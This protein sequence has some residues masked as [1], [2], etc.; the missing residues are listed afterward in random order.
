M[1]NIFITAIL[2][3]WFV[4]CST[5]ELD[6]S[7]ISDL[8][9]NGFYSNTE[10]FEIA[11]NG[12]YSTLRFFPDTQFHLQEVR[13]DNMYAITETGV[14]P[15]EPVNNLDN[16]IATNTYLSDVWDTNFEGILRVN[17]I[18]ESLNDNVVSDQATRERMEG[19]AKFLRAFFYFDLVKTFG[20]VPLI[21]QV[22]TPAQTLEIGR[23]D[24]SEIYNLIVSDLNAAISL[25]PPSFS[26]NQL[27]KATSW[28]AKAM[29]G[30]VYLTKSGPTYGI[31]G[32]GLN[33]GEYNLAID[34]FDDV[35]NNGPFDYEDDY[36]TI[37]DYDNENNSEII[38]DIQYNSG[39]EVG[40]DYPSITVPD[41]YLRANGAGFTNGEDNKRVSEDLINSYD[42]LDVRD[43]VTIID[44]YTD[45]NNIFNDVT[46][47]GKY[48]DLNFKG[49]DRFDWGLNYPVI[50]Y[51]DVQLMRAEA[52]LMSNT[53]RQTD[54]DTPVNFIR[55]R[56]GL[57]GNL[58]N[59]DIDGLLAEKRLEF[60]GENTRW[61]DLVRTGKVVQVMNAWITND[62]VSGKIATMKEDFVIYP[63]PSNQITVKEGLYQQNEGYN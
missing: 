38:F 26:G 62:D 31:E 42:L 7:P 11:I 40:A 6:Q 33:S 37:F 21:D 51:T 20:K 57:V 34:L 48:I 32:P 50:R 60:A 23:S 15:F 9:A 58:A 17:T 19:E 55:T 4:S 14:R 10:E 30:K 12:A 59:V 22:Y 35:I 56:A 49:R 53:G 41:A 52:I 27:G 44:G 54:V 2:S 47:Y 61:A 45:E 36:A 43:D 8:G 25:L 13:S 29:L 39:A 18:L 3:I 46:F 63:V 5:D 1:K 16:S 28:A 24:V